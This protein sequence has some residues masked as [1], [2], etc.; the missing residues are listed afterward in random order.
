MTYRKNFWDIKIRGVQ[1]DSIRFSI[2]YWPPSN[3]EYSTS[4]EGCFGCRIFDIRSAPLRMSDFRHSIGRP[5]NFEYST[6][7]VRPS[8]V[9]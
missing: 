9:E 8:N 4:E 7:E 3:V 6:S 5:S 1:K 2:R